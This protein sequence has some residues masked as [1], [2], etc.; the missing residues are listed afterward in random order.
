MQRTTKD[1][2]RE[3]L[4]RSSGTFISGAHI[5]EELGVSRNS[6][7][8]AVKALR[9]DGFEIE[10]VTKRGHCLLYTSDAADE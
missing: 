3:L 8:K 7:W 1:R 2:V 9:S 10:S 5:A 4:E 6:V